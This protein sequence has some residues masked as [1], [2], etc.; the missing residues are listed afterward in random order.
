[1]CNKYK[2]GRF[3]LRKLNEECVKD[4]ARNVNEKGSSDRIILIDPYV[5]VRLV[6]HFGLLAC[7]QLLVT[8]SIRDYQS[9]SE[10]HQNATINIL[11]KL[12]SADNYQM[13]SRVIGALVKT[14]NTNGASSPGWI[15]V[16]TIVY[17]FE[18]GSKTNSQEISLELT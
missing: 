9:V 18:Y 17:P 4:Q 2:G 5:L 15:V 14:D 12:P 11:F 7:L 1:M 6:V 8:Q 10:A 13:A 16:G 3:Y